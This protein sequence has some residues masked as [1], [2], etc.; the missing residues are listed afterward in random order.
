ALVIILL[1]PL[2]IF[3]KKDFFDDMKDLAKWY[4]Q[5]NLPHQNKV[6]LNKVYLGSL[7]YLLVIE[8][9]LWV[10]YPEP[11]FNSFRMR[12]SSNIYFYLLW[13]NFFM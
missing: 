1:T 13:V 4:R 6:F 2:E 9:I 7:L 12:V 8:L 3:H 5:E 10:V 11:G